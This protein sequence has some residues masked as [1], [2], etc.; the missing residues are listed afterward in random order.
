MNGAGPGQPPA[1]FAA[2]AERWPSSGRG[3][4]QSQPGGLRSENPG[5]RIFDL[6]PSR[7]QRPQEELAQG[8]DPK[9]EFEGDWRSKP[10]K[11][12]IL[13]TATTS[14]P[15]FFRAGLVPGRHIQPIR[16][17]PEMQEVD[18][19]TIFVPGLLW[20]PLEACLEEAET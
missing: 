19:E 3:Q 14:R 1:A 20:T 16:L 9:R 4:A 17:Q 2:G 5:I 13:V 7:R 12:D 11:A 10:P 18:E 6:L 8:T 15:P